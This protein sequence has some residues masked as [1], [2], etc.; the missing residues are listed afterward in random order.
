MEQEE[1]QISPESRKRSRSAPAGRSRGRGR[2]K[3][4]GA[5]ALLRGFFLL[6]MC[7][8]LAGAGW[9]AVRLVQGMSD[10]NTEQTLETPR[11]IVPETLPQEGA[12]T[13]LD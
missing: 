9:G 5:G 8:A 6:L 10:G 3:K 12:E 11:E 13:F 2:R 7:V 1:K 4:S